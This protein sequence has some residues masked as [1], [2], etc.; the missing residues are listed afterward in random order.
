MMAIYASSDI[1]KMMLK[2]MATTL[3]IDKDG[4]LSTVEK[5]LKKKVMVL[6]LD[7]IDMFFVKN[8]KG[9][10]T[11]FKTLVKWAKNND[12]HFSLIGISNSVNDDRVS[13]IRKLGHNSEIVFS[14]YGQG[15]LLAILKQRI[16]TNIVDPKALLLVA[17]RVSLL[18]GDAR[19]ALEIVAKAVEKCE[20]LLSDEK[21]DMEVKADDECMPL[22]KLPHV[23]RAIREAMPMSH[24]EVISG[25][26]QAA[27]VI[28]CIAVS[29]SQVW[30]PTAEISLSTL[31]HYCVE[32][33]HHAVMDE[34]GVGH[35]MNLVEMLIDSG[36]LVTEN[37]RRFNPQDSNTKLKIGVQLDDVEIALEQS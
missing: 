3:N 34:L 24:E 32:A 30:G 23:M 21:L 15:D 5:Q 8:S 14:T 28:L 9:A 26:P 10:K 19:R 20:A 29:L 37:K 2:E 17:K 6:I 18:S 11:W 12:Y 27:K 22:V 1:K 16:G 25:L 33:T 35:V 7:E 36:L 13:Q 4:E 31:K